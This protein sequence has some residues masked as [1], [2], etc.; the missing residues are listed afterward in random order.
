VL[1][2]DRYQDSE[3]FEAGKFVCS[4][5]LRPDGH[6][7]ALW[8][9]LIEGSIQQVSSDHAPFRFGDQ[10]TQGRDDFTRIPNGLPGIE[11]RVPLVFSEGV[12]QGRIGAERFVEITATNP[13]KIFGL[14]PKKG[15]L[16]IGADADLVLMD[17]SMETVIDHASLHSAVDYTPFQGIG[18]KGVPVA[19]VSRGEV[20]ARD[21]QPQADPG[22]GRLLDRAPVR[23]V[24]LP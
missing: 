22:R 13:A 7:A 21:G 10:K 1:T 16:Q 17:P 4:P 9:G 18:V 24:D 23:A 20:I 8:D 19:T 14:Y 5:P 6:P 15:S 11:T 2:E 12:S 3:D